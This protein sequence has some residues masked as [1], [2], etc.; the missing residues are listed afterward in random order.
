MYLQTRLHTAL[1]S[2]WL[3][4]FAATADA[5]Q[6]DAT[7]ERSFEVDGRIGLDV[8]TGSGS[9]TVREGAGDTAR[10]A[11]RLVIHDRAGLFSF[12]RRGSRLT[13]DEAQELI[14][15]FEQDPP[16]ELS[17]SRL[18]VGHIDEEWRHGMSVSYEIEVPST[19]DVRSQTGSGR[20]EIDGIEGRIV[21]RTGSG[22]VTLR[23]VVGDVEAH[24]GSGSI[25]A[26]ALAG[27]FEG[28]AGSG[29]IEVDLVT[30]G[31]VVVSTG[32][33]RIR[34]AGLDG[35]L[36]AR[37][38][39]GSITIDGQP[40]DDWELSTGS[41]TIRLRLPPEAAF[42]LDARTG[43]GGISSGHPLTVQGTIERNR[44]RGEA[45]GGGPLI[46][47]RAGSGGI[48]IE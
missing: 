38:G 5:Q 22:G 17:G 12:W 3:T 47:A 8:E 39:S 34:V 1:V 35:A 40:A 21:A 48:R 2:V 13:D 30:A 15:Q 18:R 20:M 33:G 10:V 28:R 23:D 29:S 16:V 26:A 7:F 44:L 24:S 19:T 9:V 36:N 6:A 46:T 42:S 32:S 4:A 25:R 41:G 43:S 27:G 45:G 11:G 14:R 31:D 37:A